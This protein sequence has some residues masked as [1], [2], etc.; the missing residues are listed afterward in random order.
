MLSSH[1][2][3]EI[4]SLLRINLISKKT[5]LKFPK[6]VM[7]ISPKLKSSLTCYP[8]SHLFYILNVE[9]SNNDKGRQ[10]VILKYVL[11]LPDSDVPFY[12][13][14]L[15]SSETSFSDDFFSPSMLAPCFQYVLCKR[16]I[17]HWGKCRPHCM[18]YPTFWI[19]KMEITLFL[20]FRTFW[21]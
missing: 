6:T 1:Q 19:W 3:L 12:F 14:V 18:M 2:V 11:I 5:Y 13:H 8:E 20:V 15:C 17:E 4:L 7:K 16:N 10:P 21:Q 9:E